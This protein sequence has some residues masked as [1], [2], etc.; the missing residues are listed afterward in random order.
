MLKPIFASYD[1]AA[2]PIPDVFRYCPVCRTALV[3]REIGHEERPVCPACGFIRFRNPAP[4]VSVLVVQDG[5]VLLGK[6]SSE[7]GRGKWAMPSGYVEYKDDFVSAAIREVK[8]ETG[9]D[10][11]I[12][13]ILYV[14]SA[15]ISP[16][17]HFLTVFLLAQVLGGELAATDDLEELAW[18]SL[19]GPLPEMA[20]K[21]DIDII[22]AYA[23]NGD[24]GLS[25]DAG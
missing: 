22:L 24:F 8:E 6:R 5:K 15:Y 2:Q 3:I 13:S 17:Y 25:L 4:T 11:K 7:P 12:N 21:P 19:Q 10:V 23:S 14:Q 9:L 1:P 18:V 20:F 16:E